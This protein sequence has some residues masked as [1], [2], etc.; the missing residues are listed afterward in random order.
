MNN[1]AA[2]YGVS[3][4]LSSSNAQ[5]AAG[6]ITQE[7]FKTKWKVF[8][9]QSSLG[10]FDWVI[11]TIPPEQLTPLIPDFYPYSKQIKDYKM[12]PC[13]SLM[14]GSKN[15]LDI[16]WDAAIIKNSILSWISIN[17]SKPL[18]NLNNSIVI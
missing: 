7:R 16:E 13:Y 17:D 6:N 5:Q 12:Q 9:E 1:P 2:S 10:I 15:S 11:I 8:N 4:V 18:R 14:I 3:S